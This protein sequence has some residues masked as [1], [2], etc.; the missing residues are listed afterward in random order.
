MK[1][2]YLLAMLFLMSLLAVAQSQRLVLVEEFTQASCPPCAAANPGFNAILNAN[3]TKIVPV[4]YQVSWPGTDV[5]NAQNPT[6]VATRVSYYGVTGVPQ[7]NEDGGVNGGFNGQPVTFT[8]ANVNSRYAVPSPFT[9]SVSHWLSPTHDS[10]YA[11]SVITC[12]QAVTG[13]QL[14]AQMAI[15]ERNIYFSASSP[16]GTNGELHFEQVMKQML[17]SDQGTSLVSTWNV[18]DAITIDQSWRLANVYDTNQLGVVVWV[19]DNATKTVHQAGYSRPNMARDAGVTK[20]AGLRTIACDSTA[21]P[22]VTLHNF[23]QFALTS[24]VI[25]YTIDAGPTQTYNWN[26]NLAADADILVTLPTIN[27]SNGKHTLHTWTTLPNGGTDMDTHND[28][29]SQ[30][31]NILTAPAYPVASPLVQGFTTALFPPTGYSVEN[32]DNDTYTWARS[33]VGDLNGGSAMM[34]CFNAG[35]GTMDNLYT[36]TVDFSIATT[37]ATLQFDVAHAQYSAAYAE[38]LKADVSIDCGVTWTNVYN[39]VDPSLASITTYVTTAFTPTAA[40]WRHESV[41]LNSFVGNSTILVRFQSVSGYGNDIYVDDINIY[42]SPQGINDLISDKEIN[43]YPNPTTG[44][45]FLKLSFDK[46]EDV[47]VTVNNILG[48]T[49]KSFSL[50][51][52]NGLYPIEFTGQPSGCYFV[53]IKTD[54][55][56]ITKRVFVTK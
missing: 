3:P 17:P 40:Q 4:K 46:S 54:K 7:A 43:I 5:M 10:I 12:T 41:S 14:V 32:I 36:P 35:S 18:G 16:P 56:T 52:A 29:V 15:I 42:P 31:T 48:S 49:I 30:N 38:R 34:N 11:H 20:L 50:K 8:Q 44:E 45:A 6:Q 33:S 47:T 19:Q 23:T 22:V 26:G 53:N 25:N 13:S 9:I 27:F 2:Y 51:N 28:G 37:G 21:S 24:A 1:N 55:E 39:K